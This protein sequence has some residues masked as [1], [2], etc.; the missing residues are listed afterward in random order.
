MQP[1][2]PTKLS[3]PLA[4]ARVGQSNYAAAHVLDVGGKRTGD[5][6]G[7][8]FQ[9]GK[10]KRINIVAILLMV[11]MPWLIY[12]VL[13]AVVSFS[14][15]YSHPYGTS[16]AVLL[17]F[18]LA[19]LLAFLGIQARTRDRDPMWYNFGAISVFLA[20]FLASTFG[21]LNFKYNLEPYYSIDNMNTYPSIDPAT[22]TGQQ[23][24]DAGR[25][26]FTA[27][28]GLDMSKAIGHK[29]VDIY[30]VAPIMGVGGPQESYD[31]WAIGMNCCSGAHADFRCGEYNNP[32]ARAGLRM[33]LEE[34]R[35]YYQLA[36]Q[37]A[38][39]AYGVRSEHPLF[40]YWMQDPA[41]EIMLYRD[42][43]IRYYLLG[44]F[45]HF[46][47]QLFAVTAATIAFSKMGYL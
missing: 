26:Y 5:A 25:I 13:C 3:S 20:V 42:T 30:C 46:A 43:G 34:Q 10:R 21:E 22:A 38:E 4:S 27:G 16:L 11:F 45:T 29:D 6:T 17:G 41:A 12:S 24:I 33:L 8:T 23:V 37:Q 7:S 14:F 2:V 9:A 44:I 47:C 19:G 32:H 40:F 15:H 39:A 28:A 35:P 18:L 36:V 31:F 1:D